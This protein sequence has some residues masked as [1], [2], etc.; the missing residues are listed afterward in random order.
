MRPK[1]A[2]NCAN[3]SAS[4][5][6]DFHFLIPKRGCP[7][8]L[9]V[10]GSA[11]PESRRDRRSFQLGRPMP[12]VE[13]VVCTRKPV[14]HGDAINLCLEAIGHLARERPAAFRPRPIVPR[15][16]AEHLKRLSSTCLIGRALAAR[17][18]NCVHLAGKLTKKSPLPRQV[19]IAAC[20]RPRWGLIE[21]PC[22]PDAANPCTHVQPCFQRL[23]RTLQYVLARLHLFP[24]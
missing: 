17:D 3:R 22:M 10:P 20:A 23:R 11:R 18:T 2:S 19:R 7:N 21:A 14:L 5:Y 24:P 15:E 9:P 12:L 6:Q 13:V 4:E 16:D 8:R 1:I